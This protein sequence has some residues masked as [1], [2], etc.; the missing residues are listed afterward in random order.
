LHLFTSVQQ[1]DISSI[2]ALAAKKLVECAR[3]RSFKFTA[4]EAI[5]MT[6]V[7]ENEFKSPSGAG[8]LIP[9]VELEKIPRPGLTVLGISRL[10]FA[11][12]VKS[13]AGLRGNLALCE[14]TCHEKNR[15]VK[16]GQS[17]R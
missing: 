11:F 10:L 3:E 7:E 17:K 6:F 4:E 12:V 1:D 2:G 5:K 8:I 13:K 16:S 15:S 14:P 9:E